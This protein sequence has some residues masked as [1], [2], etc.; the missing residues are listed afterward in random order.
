MKIYI[1]PI[2]QKQVSWQTT[3]TRPF[4][5][6]RC[7]TQ[8]LAA[9]GTNMYAIKGADAKNSHILSLDNDLEVI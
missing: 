2:C 7:K 1:C 3:N 5:S 6:I 4:C 9:W 8:D